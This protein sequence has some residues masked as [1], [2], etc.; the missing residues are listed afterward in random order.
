MMDL[1]QIKERL[2]DRKIHAVSEA[3]GLHRNTLTYIRDSD[4]ANPSKR[5]LASLSAYF[6][7]H[8]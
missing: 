6:E 4:G 1:D 8:P 7:A 5:T 3:T 2:R